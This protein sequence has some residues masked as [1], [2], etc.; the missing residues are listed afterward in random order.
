PD[1]RR[2]IY[3]LQKLNRGGLS[4]LVTLFDGLL[5]NAPFVAERIHDLPIASTPEHLLYWHAYTRA[6]SDSAGNNI[7]GIVNL[8]RN[9][10]AGTPECFGRFAVPPSLAGNSSHTKNLCPS[11]DN[12]PCMS[13]PVAG[14]VIRST[15]SAPKTLL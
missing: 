5:V 7:V 9:P 6:F 1:L 13:F 14:C 8:K 12:S 11:K 10:H 3:D 4:C 15:S 2:I